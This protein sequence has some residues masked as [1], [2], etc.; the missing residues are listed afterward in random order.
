MGDFI[1]H[2]ACEKCGSRDN[3]AVYSDGS[4]C[5]GCRAV[6]KEKDTSSA[7]ARPGE[8]TPRSGDFIALTKRGIHL[9]TC[10]KYGYA[11]TGEG[12]KRCHIAPYYY[13]GKL[14]AQHLRFPNKEFK[15][16]G[17]IKDG[18]EL[19]GQHLFKGGG[20]MISITEG[21]LDC[22]ALAQMQGL[23]WPV[24]SVPSGITSAPRYVA[25]NIEFL[26]SFEK[27]VFMLDNDEPGREG[28]LKCAEILSPGK[29]FIAQLP[30]K[31]AN[32]MLLAGRTQECIS[33]MWNA[34]EWRPDGVVNLADCEDRVLQPIPEGASYPYPL[35]NRMLH[36]IHP[37]RLVTITAGTG[38]GKTCFCVE[39]GYHCAFAHGL[40]GGHVALEGSVDETGRRYLGIKLG[41]PLFVPGTKFELK[42]ARDA[43]RETLGT[44][45]ISTYD[46]FGSLDPEILMSRLRYMVKSLGCK[47]II[48]DHVS[49][50]ISGL[51]IEDE[52]KALDVIMTKL[53]SF[54]EETQVSL[55][56]VS[57]L[58]RTQST[59]SHEQGMEVSLSHL[60]GSQSIAQLSDAV[61]A[62]ERDQQAT[63]LEERNT[64]KIRVL[65]NRI[66]GET[67]MCDTLCY[68]PKTGRLLG[69]SFEEGTM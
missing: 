1:R 37:G 32:D 8:W 14:V 66:S 19:F 68:D 6:T 55:F 58:K 13:K 29:A 42:A 21:E 47:W 41:V 16:A 36:G 30:L 63:E 25:D 65:K 53:R 50:M 5:F 54:V 57:H 48:L 23:K 39:L 35:L 7:P 15:W 64:T 28:A 20:K 67:G 3:L 10:K 52:R 33:A 34:V 59:S 69:M 27:V 22:L 60:R 62:L 26:E 24:V 45:M 61:I 17:R 43:F 11:V 4:Y 40:P 9:E 56:L 51:E 18:C 12:E 2:D 49:I 31:D 38:I 44:G 46:H